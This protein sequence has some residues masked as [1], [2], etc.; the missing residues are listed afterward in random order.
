MRRRES[1]SSKLELLIILPSNAETNPVADSTVDSTALSPDRAPFNNHRMPCNLMYGHYR[2]SVREDIALGKMKLLT[3]K[4]KLTP[5]TEP[6]EA[7][8][9]IDSAHRS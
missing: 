2:A 4:S 5:I 6:K 3:H 1:K 9:S 8:E 7:K